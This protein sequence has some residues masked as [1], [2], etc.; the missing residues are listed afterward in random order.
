[1]H[2]MFEVGQG[3][4][5]IA[6]DDAPRP[7]AGAP[8]PVLLAGEA[9]AVLV[10]YASDD[11]PELVD[12]PVPELLGILDFRGLGSCYFG[13]PNDEGL[14]DHP[15]Y[16]R[17]LS[18]YGVYRVEHSPW[19]SWGGTHFIVTLH[20]STFECTAE[21]LIAQAVRRRFGDVVAEAARRLH[22]DS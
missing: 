18:F 19:A 15:L 12:D 13:Y 2:R 7:E 22:E 14:H 4:R 8:M 20:D 10:Y 5:A 1:M 16:E 6:I 17:G 11:P 9:R 21:G 3:Q